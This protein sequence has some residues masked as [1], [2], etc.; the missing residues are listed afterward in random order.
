MSIFHLMSLFHVVMFPTSWRWYRVYEYSQCC[1]QA[2]HLCLFYVPI[3][4]ICLSSRTC[5][6]EWVFNEERIFHL[7]KLHAAKQEGKQ[8]EE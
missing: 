8:N 5:L 6:G 3:S 7:L 4:V 2:A 1:M